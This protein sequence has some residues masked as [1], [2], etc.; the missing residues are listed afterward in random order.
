MEFAQSDILTPALLQAIGGLVFLLVFA[1]VAKTLR[2]RSRQRRDAP[3]LDAIKKVPWPP[4]ARETVYR[5]E[6][7]S[8]LDDD[9]RKSIQGSS[10]SAVQNLETHV[11][12]RSKAL[13]SDKEIPL[14]MQVVRVPIGGPAASTTDVPA[15]TLLGVVLNEVLAG[16]AFP[17]CTPFR[18][19][20][21][22]HL[23]AID[24]LVVDHRLEVVH[25]RY[26]LTL[27]GLASLG[28]AA[29]IRELA[30][31]DELLQDLKRVYRTHQGKEWT[32]SELAQ[33]TGRPPEELARQLTWVTDQPILSTRAFSEYTALVLR[34]Q[35]TERVLRA[36]PLTGAGA[37]ERARGTGDSGR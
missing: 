8:G 20:H 32:V 30:A 2:D 4:G 3:V 16:G 29:A 18:L 31:C 23:S 14:R 24:Q 19:A 12:E 35:L 25:G 7:A 13:D 28:S 33:A 21:E 15:E 9:R 34:I 17:Q 5:D 37:G 36:Q 6:L 11:T 22:A 27:H 26:R 10:T 1:I